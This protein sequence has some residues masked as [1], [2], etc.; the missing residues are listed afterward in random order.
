MAKP[1]SGTQEFTLRE[2]LATPYITYVEALPNEDGVWVRKASCPELDGCFVIAP[3]AWE[4]IESLELFLTKYLV[5]RVATGKPVPRPQHRAIVEDLSAE[6]LLERAGLGDWV[7]K[8]D[9]QINAVDGAG[10][11]S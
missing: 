5:D 1:E 3:R 6:D 9:D 2:L 7:A 11:G 10:L 8:L 4:A